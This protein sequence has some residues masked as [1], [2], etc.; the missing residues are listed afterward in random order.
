VG[1]VLRRAGTKDRTVIAMD[2]DKDTLDMV[3]DGVIA[4]TVAQKPFTM[5]YVGV[6]MLDALYHN[7]LPSMAKSFGPDPY[8]PIPAFV[9]TGAAL[10]DQTNV[11]QYLQA[12]KH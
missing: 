9:D 6:M 2:V 5:G 4:A 10:V 7:P 1:E 3:K 11:D 12:Q 8:A